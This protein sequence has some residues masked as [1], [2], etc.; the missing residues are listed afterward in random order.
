[1]K[2]CPSCELNFINDDE[3]L[4]SVCKNEKVKE[5]G[6]KKD[7]NKKDVENYLIPFLRECSQEV[8]D[9]FTKKELSF[10]AFKIRL[11]LLIE[12]QNIDKE[13]CKNEVRVGCSSNYRYYIEPYYINGKYYHICSQWANSDVEQSKFWLQIVKKTMSKK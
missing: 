4:C 3:E 7:D 6:S 12:C 2:K 9:S 11:P 1:M 10:E 5:S 8:I 13:H